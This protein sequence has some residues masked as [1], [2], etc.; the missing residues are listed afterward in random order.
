MTKR[1][2]SAQAR[3]SAKVAKF[4]TPDEYLA[5]VAEDKRAALENL[6]ETI[7]ETVP[8]AEE[9]ISYGLPSFRL[10]GKTF[11]S[12]GTAAKHS[13]FYA[14]ATVQKFSDE[15]KGY[16]TSKGT[17]RF[18]SDQPLPKSLIRRLVKQR[19]KDRAMGRSNS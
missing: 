4:E 6:R 11:L 18:S 8:Q 5:A 17:I 2:G 16:E 9:C 13:A 19:L 3:A 14:G 12:Y 7:R 15:L 1:N 10:N